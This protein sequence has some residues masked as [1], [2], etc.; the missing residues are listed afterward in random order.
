RQNQGTTD[1]SIRG[2]VT[3]RERIALQSDSDLTVEL[4]QVDAQGNEEDVVAQT[5]FSTGTRQVPISFELPYA[6]SSI[7]TNGNYA[8]RAS[9]SHSGETLFET[10]E[11]QAVN[12][13]RVS[14]NV[15]LVLVKG[16]TG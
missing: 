2:T 12:L 4:V 3:Y 13:G 6:Q 8:V 11:P 15:Q 5:T 1:R 14:N 7:E 9:I 10:A 16:E